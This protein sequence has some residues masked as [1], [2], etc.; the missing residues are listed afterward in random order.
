LIITPDKII[1]HYYLHNSQKII[2]TTPSNYPQ[3]SEK[4]SYSNS[5]VI[6]KAK[7][8]ELK[9]GSM[10][11]H[12]QEY[13]LALAKHGSF[14][15]AAE[16]LFIAQPTLS[17]FL[18]RLESS[19]GIRLFERIGKRLVLTYAGERYVRRAREILTTFRQV[20]PETEIQLEEN[21]SREL[22]QMLLDGELDLI[23]SNHAFRP[24]L[25]EIIPVYRDFM[26]LCLPANH[27]AC[28]YAKEIPGSVYGWLDLKYL[29]NERFILQKTTQSIRGFSDHAFLFCGIQ[30]ARTFIIE[31]L[32]T[33]T[34]MAAEGYG[35]S[36]N[37]ESYLRHFSYPKQVALYRTGDL[38]QHI[39]IY[40]AVRNGQFLP[41][42]QKEF[43]RLIQEYF[44]QS[45]QDEPK[46]TG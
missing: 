34:Q 38:N 29:G 20:Y 39:T 18:N 3:K 46:Y 7:R 26:L 35:A 4:L 5:A 11:L 32:E 42:Y 30:P 8:Y 41:D 28:Q 16:E 21:S 10:D 15:K 22:E 40:I 23:I 9:G 44:G 17:I 13:V 37:F 12:E 25:L 36:F 1:L 33:A 43:I 31:N 27:P 14:K 45:Q 2:W 24:D 19:L 6:S